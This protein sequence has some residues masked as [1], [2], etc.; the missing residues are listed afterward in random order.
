[1]Q[2][3]SR[4]EQTA[5]LHAHGIEHPEKFLE[6]AEK[7]SAY[8]FLH[9]PQNL[10][11]LAEVVK[12]GNWPRTRSELFHSTTQLLLTEHSKEH[13]RQNAGIYASDELEHS[14]GSICALRILSDVSGIS[15]LP[16]DIR[17]EYPSYRTIPFFSREIVRATLSRRVFSAGDELETV[18]YSHRTIAE[19][20]AAKWLASIVEKGLPLGRLRSLLGFEGYPSSELRGLHAWLAVFLPQYTN[21]FIQADP[22]G[23][24]TYGDAASLST[25]DK[26]SLL[27]ALSKLSERDPWFRNHGFSSNLNGFVSEEM[28]AHL[29]L[30]IHDHKSRFSLRMLILESL[31]V[32]TP[33]LSLNQDLIDIVKSERHSYAEKEEAITAL[34]HSG[35]SGIKDVIGIYSELKEISH[36]NIRL[37]NHIIQLLYKDYFS[38]LDVAQLLIDTLSITKERLPVGSL[39][40]IMDVVSVEDMMTIFECLYQYQNEN[41]DNWYSSPRN[42]HEVLYYIESGL[43]TILN[44]KD[45]YTAEQIWI[46]LNVHHWYKEHYS[47]FE[48]KTTQ[49]VQLLKER[50]WQYE[51]II[52]AAI[53][54]FTR[55]NTGYLFLHEFGQSTFG[56]IP[57]EF[58][59]SRFIHYLSSKECIPDKTSFIYR[60]AFPALWSCDMPSQQ[61]FEFLITYG[62]MNNELLFI[63]KDALV[64]DIDDWRVKINISRVEGERERQDII[65]SNKVEFQQLR[66]EIV[67]G[68][69]LGWLRHIAYI[70][71]ALY[72]DVDEKLFCFERLSSSLGDKNAIDAISGLVALLGRADLPSIDDINNSLIKGEYYEWWYAILAGSDELWKLEDDITLWDSE[73]LKML[74][75]LDARLSIHI[76][77][78]NA[79]TTYSLPW[80]KYVILYRGDLFIETYG[81]IIDFCM[82]NKFQ[83]IVALSFILHEK[84]LPDYLVIPLVIHFAKKYPDDI[85]HTQSLVEW[86]LARPQIHR[87]LLELSQLMV[88]Q[89][90]VLN[91]ISYNVW[92]VCYYFLEPE[93]AYELFVSEAKSDSEIIWFLRELRRQ[94][95]NN[96]QELSLIQLETIIRVSAIHFPNAYHPMDGSHGSRNSWDYAEFIRALINEVSAISSYD[97]S[98][99]LERLLLLPECESYWDHLLHAQSNQRIRYREAQFH[100]ADWKQAVSTLVNETPANVMDLYSLL[101]DHIRDI[102]NRITYENTNIYKQFWNEDSYGRPLAPKP[103]E[104][105]RNIFLDLLRTRLNPLKISCEPEGHM[106]SDKRADIIVSL[107][108]IKIP[109]EIKR[110]YHRDV[111]TALNGQLDKLYT[112]NPDSAGYGIYLVFWFGSARPNPL[113]RLAKNMP[114][115]E[116]ASSM[117]NML[118]ETVPVEK[119]DRL[120]AIVIDVSGAAIPLVETSKSTV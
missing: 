103:E 65:D 14:A 63:L 118:N 78:D 58:L 26:Q 70:Y 17:S 115:P 79:I 46:C 77:E 43:V 82:K 36:D 60:L 7:H 38:A 84:S 91:K 80:K 20:L 71:Y 73:L 33:I 13:S 47:H 5:I 72:S 88:N 40:G 66:E 56:V 110:D 116:N 4:E 2:Q 111:W 19:Y 52:D 23:V 92:L 34:I 67:S 51:D 37:R 24:L 45:Q 90:N 28:E 54:S 41:R 87:D 95:K 117:E 39:W 61:V 107:P 53:S 100:H 108:G 101:L 94:R 30:I 42:R 105:C 55:Y 109:I 114:Q 10:L 25:V 3:L 68:E 22:Y 85:N 9:N 93:K 21:V 50:D 16:N 29:R 11:M 49:I 96:N 89:R 104:S 32:T 98:E 99:A 27:V 120:S 74:I 57:R 1:M 83:H 62:K 102:S 75:A 112:K 69:H 76:K 6:E 59:L 119:R 64:C 106:V 81:Y 113:P 48:S 31:S 86:L 12:E 8:E 18:D 44:T 15:L 35:L 97:A